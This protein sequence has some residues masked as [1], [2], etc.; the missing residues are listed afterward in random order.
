[1]TSLSSIDFHQHVPAPHAVHL[2]TA[3]L[4]SCACMC[5]AGSFAQVRHSQDMRAL[6]PSYL[7]VT[8]P[9]ALEHRI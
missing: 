5:W 2:G 3:C 9:V 1:M 4:R 8:G 7:S 6:Y